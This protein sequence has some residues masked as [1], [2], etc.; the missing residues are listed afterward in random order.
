MRTVD[1][2]VNKLL[3]ISEGIK[4]LNASLVVINIEV[5]KLKSKKKKTLCESK[6]EEVVFGLTQGVRQM[7]FGYDGTRYFFF[8]QFIFQS[9]RIHYS[10]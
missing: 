8:L 10:L 6:M 5:A 1:V 4:T 3:F 7:T 9:L 2:A